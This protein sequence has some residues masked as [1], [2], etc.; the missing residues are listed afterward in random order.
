MAKQK[1]DIGKMTFEQ[2]IDS[3]TGIVDGI[4]A[5]QMPLAESIENYEKGMALI[6]HCRA[7]LQ[8]AEKKIEKITTDQPE[9]DK[10]DEQENT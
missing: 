9:Q 2:A 4:E 8:T 6:K 3:L 10:Q 7:I 1:N 5:G